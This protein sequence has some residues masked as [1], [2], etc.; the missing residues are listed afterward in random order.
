MT[1][2]M[3]GAQ[4]VDL[5]PD[6]GTWVDTSAGP[7]I[8][9]HTTEGGSVA[10]AESAMRARGV[11]SHLTYDPTSRVLHQHVRLDR[12]AMALANKRGG[13]QTNRRK[14][15][16]QVEIVGYAGKTHEMPEWWYRNIVDDVIRPLQQMFSVPVVA[17]EF[18]GAMHGTI[19]TASA[20]QRMSYAEWNAYTGFCGHQHVP[21]NHHWDPGFFQWHLVTRFLGQ[22]AAAPGPARKP[23]PRSDVPEGMLAWTDPLMVSAAIGHWQ[24]FL[25]FYCEQDLGPS[26]AD[27]AFGEL[28]DQGTRNFQAFFGLSVDGV[29]GPD[30][31]GLADYVVAARKE[32]E[33]DVLRAIAA[34]WAGIAARLDGGSVLY[35]RS[36]VIDEDAKWVQILL[37]KHGFGPLV[38][39]GQYGAKTEDAVKAFQ[40]ARGLKVDGV[41]GP[42]T[43]Q[44]LTK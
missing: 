16:I 7:V 31:Q 27:D 34:K 23:R 29:V 15:V 6:G 38:E 18:L 25:M 12:S 44:E 17:P 4:F 20:R 2:F 32:Q 30:T 24:R 21:E 3:P 39:D 28:T 14:Q 35:R 8:V 19:A 22:P 10:G 13:V 11:P 40:R 1:V 42:V 9:L 43:W 36:G 26:G 37:N 33:A 5:G 41:V